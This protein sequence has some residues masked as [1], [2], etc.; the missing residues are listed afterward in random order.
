MT[1]HAQSERRLLADE[2]ERL[3]PDAPTINEGWQAKELAAHLVLRETRPDLI[4]GAFVPLL[5]GRLDR[6]MA[7]T[8]SGDWRTLV[9]KVRSGPPSWNPMSFAAVDEKANLT[10]FFV[11]LE[12]LRRA[13]PDWQ[14]RDL[15]GD[16]EEALWGQLKAAGRLV[17]R[18][19]PTGVVLVADGLGRHA[20]KGPGERGTVVLRGEVG[21]LVMAVFGRERVADVVV[22]GD[23]ADVAAFRSAD[24]GG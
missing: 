14:P 22:E 20:A 11:H 4:A 18:K 24:L 2:L 16:K 23:H 12:D 13:Q 5:S 21:E 8:A 17:L 6:A 9:Q 19:A 1:R 15:P 10:E 3:G 7:Q